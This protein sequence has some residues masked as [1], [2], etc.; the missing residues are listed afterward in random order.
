V[1]SAPHGD[2]DHALIRFDPEA[3]AYVDDPAIGRHR[4]G[5]ALRRE[6]RKNRTG[7][8][9]HPPA[10]GRARSPVISVVEVGYVRSSEIMTVETEA[11][12]NGDCVVPYKCPSRLLSS[13]IDYLPSVGFPSRLTRSLRHVRF[14]RRFQSV[15][16]TTIIE[17]INGFVPDVTYNSPRQRPIERH[18]KFIVVQ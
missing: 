10:A 4:P 17:I 1:R 12:G 6:D 18:G 16:F 15:V 7:I 5:T 13:C 11:L 2:D 3:A 14:Q 8:G 9:P